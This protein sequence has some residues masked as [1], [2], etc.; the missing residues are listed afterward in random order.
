MTEC[1][2]S[3]AI[4]QFGGGFAMVMRGGCKCNEG[5]DAE[6]MR[7]GGCKGNEGGGVA[8][9]MRGGLQM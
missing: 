5:G 4:N 8:K 9:V 3:I 6:V 2:S 7:G 1:R